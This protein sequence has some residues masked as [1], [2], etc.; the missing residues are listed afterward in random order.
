MTERYP[1]YDVLQKRN[2]PSW[3]DITRRVVD[4]RLA[5]P[6]HAR[7]FTPSE[8][9]TLEAVC[10]RIV[11]QP[12]RADPVKLPAYVDEKMLTN[13][14]DGFRYP[15]MPKQGDAWR[16]GLAALDEAAARDHGRRFHDLAPTQQDAMLK[17]VQQG[18]FEA[19][20]LDGMPPKTFFTTRIVTDV[21]EAY[22]SHPDAWNEIGWGG[23]ASPRG[24]VRLDLGL[25]DP[26]EPEEAHSADAHHARSIN[27]HVR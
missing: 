24:Y 27:R 23:P 10:A 9:Q 1:G 16:R 8:W 3:N 19:A 17:A 7:F 18:E 26:W 12:D 15:G 21:V 6:D 4:A 13:R 22:Y 11:P 25:R 5:V 2:S 14:A 20:A